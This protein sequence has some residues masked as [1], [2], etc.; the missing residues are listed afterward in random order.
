MVGRGDFDGEESY[1]EPQKN[2]ISTHP[3]EI[4]SEK[5]FQILGGSD[6]HSTL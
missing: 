3:R 1:E 6:A 2:R 4:G 5:S